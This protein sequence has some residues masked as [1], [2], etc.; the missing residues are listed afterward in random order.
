[1]SAR[2]VLVN[3]AGSGIGRAVA[4]AFADEGCAVTIAGRTPGPLE[5]TDGG[6]GMVC[7]IADVTD[8]AATRALFESPFDVVIANAGGGVAARIGR[9]SLA[10]WNR[11]LAVNLTGVFLT[12]RAALATMG[13]GGRLIAIASTAGLRGGAAI[14]AYAAAK[15]GVIGLVRSVALDVAP[16]AITCNAICPGVVD[17]PLAEAAIAAVMAR[18]GVDRAAALAE[19]VSENP[20]GRLIDP[21]E[22]AAAALYLASPAAGSVNG[23]ALV[24]SGGGT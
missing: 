2:R 23:H 20:A 24:L 18:R 7:R 13:S 5:E 19:V 8:E 1:M 9:T 22:V 21:S 14:P 10:E 16:R 17:T 15:H 6:R 12:F 3:G 4:R 11:T